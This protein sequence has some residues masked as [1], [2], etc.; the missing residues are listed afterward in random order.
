MIFVEREAARTLETLKRDLDRET[1]E[2]EKGLTSERERDRVL[3]GV[4]PFTV[5][6]RVGE[7]KRLQPVPFD[8]AAAPTSSARRE[9]GI[10]FPPF[11]PSDL[12]RRCRCRFVPGGSVPVPECRRSL[13]GV[14]AVRW[15]KKRGFPH[16]E[17][18]RHLRQPS[19]FQPPH[20]VFTEGWFVF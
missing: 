17:F 5:E 12:G 4:P 7:I 13:A 10:V 19:L 15:T 3:A 6:G 11:R 9:H 16:C 1:R 20:V 2:L 14:W 18:H 8:G